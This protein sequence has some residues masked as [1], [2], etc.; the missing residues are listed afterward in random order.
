LLRPTRCAVICERS[1]A[2]PKRGPRRPC[3]SA[4]PRARRPDG[5]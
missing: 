3:W 2:L 5:P 1:A 4:P